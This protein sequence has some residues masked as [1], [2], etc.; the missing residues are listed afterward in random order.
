MVSYYD[1]ENMPAPVY[2]QTYL[3]FNLAGKIC[4][5]MKLFRRKSRTGRIY[6]EVKP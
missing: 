1:H 5:F 4:Q 3:A 2:E 6:P